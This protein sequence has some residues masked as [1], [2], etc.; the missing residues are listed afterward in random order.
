M[1]N[2]ATSGN[3]GKR[4]RSDCFVTL[5]IKKSGGIDI[6]LE[7]KVKVLFGESI[8]K[9]INEIFEFFE[10][11]DA[12]IKDNTFLPTRVI[13]AGKKEMSWQDFLRGNL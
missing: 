5:E 10:I 6:Q 8:I 2:I 1:G 9:L 11:K 13:P 4:V 7:S 3:K 12:E